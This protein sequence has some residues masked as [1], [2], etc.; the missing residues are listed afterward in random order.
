LL[1]VPCVPCLGV[2]G[3]ATSRQVRTD[4]E[5]QARATAALAQ[6]EGFFADAG[7]WPESLG[8]VDAGGVGLSYA[9]CPDGGFDLTWSEAGVGFFPS[10]F[11]HR[12]NQR[13]RSWEL[14]ELG[15][16]PGCR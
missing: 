3:A 9:P 11:G 13:E 2:C 15:A 8:A 12:W 10:D 16:E 14:Y 6:L 1:L 4:R 7:T 5:R